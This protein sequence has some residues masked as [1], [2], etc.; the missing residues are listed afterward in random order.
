LIDELR[1]KQQELLIRESEVEGLKKLL[2]EMRETVD[3]SS[4][5]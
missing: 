4:D 2:R 1:R 5:D 3:R